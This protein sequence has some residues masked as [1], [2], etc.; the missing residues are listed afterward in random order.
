MTTIQITRKTDPSYP[1]RLAILPDAPDTLYYIGSLPDDMKPTVGIV[2]ARLC[3]LYGKK[4][5]EEFGR[6]LA[7]NDV[8][9]I[10]GMAIGIDSLSQKGALSAKGKTF[11][12]LGSGVDVCYPP[13]NQALYDELC[14][15]G[16]V[17]SEQTPGTPPLKHNFPLRNRLISAF[18]DILLVVEAK[19]KSGSLI[20]VDYALEQGK[21]VFAIPGR[22]G[23][24]L[25]DGCN[26]LIAQGAGI[27]Y[28]PEAIL[29]ELERIHASSLRKYSSLDADETPSTET[30]YREKEKRVLE[31]STLSEHAKHVYSCL[32]WTDDLS[33]DEIRE[34][35]RLPI[36]EVSAILTE[37]LLSDLVWMPRLNHYIRR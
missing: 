34:E 33:T 8:Q 27:A 28:S 13:G 12:V 9:I 23:D 7:Q 15:K 25:S 4:T 10:S 3:D 11:A 5:A 35:T 2:G 19:E 26:R 37:L 17:I 20:T 30:V 6:I 18:S 24:L 14:T 16:G 31:N 21:S 1:K 36:E 29:D 32:S 22:V